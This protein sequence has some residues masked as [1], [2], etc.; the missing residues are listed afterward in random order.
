MKKE[1]KHLVVLPEVAYVR[2]NLKGIID[3][4]YAPEG[5][6]FKSQ[7]IEIPMEF[8]PSEAFKAVK[9]L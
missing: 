8:T 6:L 9:Y 4:W 2:T 1:I 7:C 5:K 3:S